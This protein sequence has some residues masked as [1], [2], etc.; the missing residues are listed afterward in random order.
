M[1]KKMNNLEGFLALSAQ[2]E[3]AAGIVSGQSNILNGKY[4][5]DSH[6]SSCNSSS[7][8]GNC[9]GQAVAHAKNVLKKK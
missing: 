7:G 6:C 5:G 1:V 2:V 8:G 9:N 3:G 4:M